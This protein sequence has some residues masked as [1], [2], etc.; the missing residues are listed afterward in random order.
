MT[1]Q[2]TLPPSFDEERITSDF[3]LKTDP[4]GVLLARS[5]LI[6][7][8]LASSETNKESFKNITSLVMSDL[9]EKEFIIIAA[10]LPK[11]LRNIMFDEEVFGETLF[12]EQHARSL[13]DAQKRNRELEYHIEQLKREL[14]RE[15]DLRISAE[16]DVARSARNSLGATSVFNAILGEV[17]NDIILVGSIVFFLLLIGLI[18]FVLF[19][20]GLGWITSFLVV[21]S[22]VIGF[23]ARLFF[24]AQVRP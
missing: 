22:V 17:N 19:Y 24:G 18:F 13:L 16:F 14:M 8:A 9:T 3:L 1:D 15:N 10:T 4:S 5:I 6:R 2:N 12:L 11:T 20:F 7:D 23:G 21:V